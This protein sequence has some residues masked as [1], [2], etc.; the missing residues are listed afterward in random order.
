MKVWWSR[1]GFR[2]RNDASLGSHQTSAVPGT[3]SAAGEGA[4]AIAGSAEI[5]VSGH[6]NT[7]VK[8]QL[9]PDERVTLDDLAAAGRA[10]MVQRWHAAGVPIAVAAE[11]ADSLQLGAL[12]TAVAATL[13]EAGV[14]VLEGDF[15]AGKSLAAERQHQQD[16]AAARADAQAPIPVHL[17][18]QHISG[19]VIDAA[20]RMARALG[21][22]AARGVALVVDGLDEPGP[23]RGK[24]LLD[25]ALSWTASATNGRWRIMGTARPG[26][27][28]DTEVR[29]V[30]PE[31]TEEE[32]AALMDRLGGSG[33][34]VHSQ[35]RMVRS[36]LRRPLFAIIGAQLQSD[37]ERLPN[38]PVAFLDA[39]VTRALRNVESVQEERAE[40]L[41][42]R[43]AAAC[44]NTGGVA[45][46][47]DV[48][49]PGEV[50]ALLGTRLVVRL[51]DRY[52]TFALPVLEQYFAGQALLAGGVLAEVVQSAELLDRWR[53]GLAMAIASGGWDSVRTVLDP[54][55]RMNPGVAAWAVHEAIPQ[56]PP[57]GKGPWPDLPADMVSQRLQETLDGWQQ[58]LSPAGDRAFSSPGWTGQ[59]TVSAELDGNKLGLHI[60]PRDGDHTPGLAIPVANRWVEPRGVRPLTASFGA[61][62]VEYAAWPWQKTLN[63]LTS[64]LHTLCAHK[65]F[66]LADCDAYT[67][68]RLWLAGAD[69]IGL[70]PRRFTPLRA[71]EVHEALR[72]RLY[73]RSGG[74]PVRSS[75]GKRFTG[76]QAELLRLDE[77]L[78]SGRWA[79]AHGLLHSPYAVPDQEESLQ[80]YWVWDAYSPEQLRLRTEQVLTAAVEIYTALVNTWFPQLKQV[81]GLSCAAPAALIGD[82]FTAAPRGQ[83]S[84]EPPKMRLTLCPSSSGSVTV[85]LIPSED[86][87]YALAPPLTGGPH[88]TRTPWA[89]PSTPVFSE[90]E[91]FDDAPATDYAYAWL[92]EDLH[93]L[94]LTD[95]GPRTL[96]TGL[97]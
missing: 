5:V 84:Y 25:Q 18:A 93:R 66:D 58:A 73:G 54:L 3:V 41:L 7:V 77:E 53:Y 40:R 31:L 70:A 64:H 97:P 55:L 56:A 87:F 92:H 1:F 79:D 30:V 76:R 43:L 17:V 91:I 38:S 19:N 81:L 9:L 47:A 24:E 68:E 62:A 60:L 23:I 45:A 78:D 88:P 6:G 10:R 71:G 75:F 83:D 33:L 34:A 32:A 63:L 94:H 44:A 35:S 50:R 46:T 74:V 49:S 26:L 61:A 2:P 36:V 15:G 85:H 82:L 21:D 59:V 72:Q 90:P 48:G 42:Q 13:P 80:R 57:E 22:P 28:M 69:L 14:V 67:K 4:I 20:S 51:G 89:R 37:H 39:L 29:R 95:N 96:R 27:E 16:I 86:A 8:A 12:S 52:L 65:D 11:F